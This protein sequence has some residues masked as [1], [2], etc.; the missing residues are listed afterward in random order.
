MR[1]DQFDPVAANTL[2]LEMA[3][4]AHGIVAAG[5]A[6]QSTSERRAAYMRYV[7]QGHEIPIPLPDRPLAAGDDGLLRR[8]FERI[9]EQMFARFIP[10]AAIEILTWTVTVSTPH[11]T[12][13]RLGAGT[14][15]GS[16]KPTGKRSVFDPDQERMIEIPTYWRPDLKSGDSL[17]GPAVIAEDETSTFITARFRASINPAGCIVLE[18][19]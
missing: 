7:G 1:L 17:E 2:L 6:G 4:E 14:A 18:R 3:E 16:A 5:A 8:D 15:G 19:R 11:A 13:A 9:Y 10:S 12:P